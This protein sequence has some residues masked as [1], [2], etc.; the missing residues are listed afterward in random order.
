MHQIIQIYLSILKFD[1]FNLLFLYKL[2]TSVYYMLRFDKATYLS[3]L[4]K[5]IL[6]K[7]LNSQKGSGV[8]LFSEFISITS[9]LY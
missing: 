6:S 9:I 7:R 5:F 8:L 4:F 1:T 2:F 3:L